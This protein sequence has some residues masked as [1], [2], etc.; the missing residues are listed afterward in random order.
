AGF[1]GD[2]A[3]ID[4]SGEGAV[5]AVAGLHA[6]VRLGPGGA[7]SIAWHDG[8][9]IRFTTI[10]EGEDGIEAGVLYRVK[11]GSVVCAEP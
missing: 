5:I 3:R 7:A 10:Y 9:R 4:I 8:K 2:D 1:S 6:V 11:K